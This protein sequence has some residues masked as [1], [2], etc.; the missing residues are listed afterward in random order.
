M[1][2]YGLDML[3]YGLDM[4]FSGAFERLWKA[5]IRFVISVC[6]SVCLTISPHETNRLP[7]ELFAW[8]LIF[9]YFSKNC[10]HN[11]SFTNKW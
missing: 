2:F 7:L 5:T 3:F 6:P 10:R 8:N 9:E 4:L 1:Q 11:S